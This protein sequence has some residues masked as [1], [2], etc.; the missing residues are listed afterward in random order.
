MDGAL[1]EIGEDGIAG[2]D[3]RTL[4]RLGDELWTE[5]G[6]YK[7]KVEKAEGGEL[8]VVLQR[9]RLDF[10]LDEQT[11]RGWRFANEQR[12]RIDSPPLT[13]D[14]KLTK[15]CRLHIEYC[16]ANKY[17]GHF[18]N[19]TKPGYT[20][21]GAAAGRASVLG[22]SETIPV[23]SALEMLR[24]AYHCAAVIDPRVETSA[25]A[26]ERSIFCWDVGRGTVKSRRPEGSEYRKDVLSLWPPHG[27]KGVHCDFNPHGER[28][29]PVRDKENRYV[30]NL[31]QCVFAEVGEAEGEGFYDLVLLGPRGAA[32]EGFLTTPLRPVYTGEVKGVHVRNN[33]N[34]VCFAPKKFL[35]SRTE[36]R[37][38]LYEGEFK[39]KKLILSWSFTTRSR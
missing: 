38:E 3:S 35:R 24:T 19:P 30:T 27:A 20:Q 6:R 14:E 32:V 31:G 18:Q 5:E 16:V 21:E 12:G 13:W 1:G 37:A 4:R 25:W 29:M 26:L 22:Y 39:K 8:T 11:L 28:P 2:P 17:T 15:G 10:T 36:Y 34:L 9:H 23:K 7:L 33:G